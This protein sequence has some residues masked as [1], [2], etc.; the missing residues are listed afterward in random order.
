MLLFHSSLF[1]K[2]ANKSLFKGQFLLFLKNVIL[3]EE[4]AC[5]N[6]VSV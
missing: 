3:T 6:W 5:N 4:K 2:Y 1:G